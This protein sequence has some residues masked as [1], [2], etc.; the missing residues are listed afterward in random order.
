VRLPPNFDPDQ[1]PE[2][3]KFV[4]YVPRDGYAWRDDVYLMYFLGLLK[5][6]ILGPALL[7]WS[8]WSNFPNDRTSR[9]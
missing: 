4:M 8:N 3:H 7:S 2:S 6:G 1:P 5:S 9:W